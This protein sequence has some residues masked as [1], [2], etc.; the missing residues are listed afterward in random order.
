MNGF[1]PGATLGLSPTDE[2]GYVLDPW[3]N[4][5]RYNVA[6][7]TIGGVTNPFTTPNGMQ[8]AT[9]ATLG[10]A[11]LI[12]VCASSVGTTATSCGTAP[13]LST[14]APVLL[15]ST[16]KNGAGAG[17]DE[18]ANRDGNMVF[19]SHVPTAITSSNGEFDDIVAWLSPNILY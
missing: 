12:N 19:V 15:F 14:S 13:T 1:L 11:T 17:A 3:G 18:S 9:L 2:R 10:A 6:N 5:I 8:S 16:G 7:T 4:P